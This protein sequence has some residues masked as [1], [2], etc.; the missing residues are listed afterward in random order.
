MTPPGCR[1]VT[2]ARFAPIGRNTGTLTLRQPGGVMYPQPQPGQTMYLYVPA[3]SGWW[4][5]MHPFT[6]VADFGSE[7]STSWRH[8]ITASK[9][10]RWTD[11][12]LA[13]AH[14]DG[15]EGQ[16]DPM[17]LNS[18]IAGVSS[19]DLERALGRGIARPGEGASASLASVRE[20][21]LPKV[22]V[23]GPFGAACVVAE[24]RCTAMRVM[25]DPYE[26]G[27]AAGPPEAPRGRQQATLLF[28]AGAGITPIAALLEA[29][30]RRRGA[31]LEAAAKAGGETQ[32]PA[33]TLVWAVRDLDLLQEFVPLLDMLLA[34]EGGDAL[35]LY[36]TGEPGLLP[37]HAVYGA[38]WRPQVGRPDV[39][40]LIAQ[41]R[42]AAEAP[43]LPA[44]LHVHCCGPTALASSVQKACA[45]SRAYYPKIIYHPENFEL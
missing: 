5:E 37:A 33:L 25:P 7:A 43:R 3:V 41:A 20:R 14:E 13:L 11:K 4:P 24:D 40:R 6:A 21:E 16:A 22:Y 19:P 2:T 38:A 15:P 35:H 23:L 45:A 32:R 8:Y 27:Q 44:T 26:E 34:D 36:Y 9:N 17:L 42:Q 12:L 39:N 30:L 29:H 31:L 1:A 28:A 10:G 18:P